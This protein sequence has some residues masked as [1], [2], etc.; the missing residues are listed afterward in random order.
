M[1]VHANGIVIHYT[2]EGEGVPILLLHGNGEDHSIFGRF[3][4][5]LKRNHKVFAMDTRGHGES[6]KVGSFHYSDMVEDAAAFIREL[7]IWKPILY[8]FS[9]G[10][11]VGLMLA[12]KY[13]DM[14]SGLIASGANLTPKD[15]KWS[16]RAKIRLA[17]AY[18]RDPL[19]SLMLREPCITDEDLERIEAPVLITVADKDITAVSHAERIADKIRN[20]SVAVV[21]GEDHSSYVINSEKLFPLTSDFI[22][23]VSAARRIRDH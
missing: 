5:D 10:G 3:A 21:P 16:F 23:H 9:D 12:S 13:P 19:L 8:G 11:I 22:E 15:L 2:A 4:E 18:R 6:E 7:D 20:G 17:N 1:R 14:L